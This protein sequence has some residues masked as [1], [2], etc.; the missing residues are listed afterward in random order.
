MKVV[1]LYSGSENLGIESLSAYL[2]AN[3]HETA[4]VFDPAH[5]RGNSGRDNPTLAGLFDPPREKIIR[6]VLKEEPD[7]LALSCVTGNYR[8]A[9]DLTAEI[10]SRLKK[11]VPAVFGGFHPSMAPERVISRPAVDALV[12]GEGEDALL[13]LIRSVKDGEFTDTGVA[14]AW[15]KSEGNIHRNPVRPYIRDLDRLPFPDKKLFYRKVPF[16]RR[17]YMVMTA[18]GCPYNCT[19]CINATYHEIYRA[20]KTHIRRYSPG[21]IIEEL[22]LARENGP[23][24]YINIYDDIFTLDLKWIEEFLP[25]YRREIGLPFF[26]NIHPDHCDENRVRLIKEAGCHTVRLG[27]Q[28]LH[29]PTLKKTLHRGGLREKVAMALDNLRKY[30]IRAKVEYILGLPGDSPE[31]QSDA[32]AFYNEHRPTKVHSFWLIPFPGTKIL[33]TAVQ[34]GL[35]TES[36]AEDFREADPR[37]NFT[38]FHYNPTSGAKYRALNRFPL[39][40][41]LL[42]LLP[43][44]TVAQIIERKLYRHFPYSRTLHQLLFLLNALINNDKEDIGS[45]LYIFVKKF[46]P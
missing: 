23:V 24:D 15:V 31:I 45:F 2:K 44:K 5:F 43:K 6:A 40:F 8:W 21:R 29:D 12:I 11:P 39:L 26:C 4:L 32:A 38:T 3:G 34:R 42:T 28:T 27:V 19:F 46:T 30:G 14:N 10:K 36:E 41:D 25:V 18:R 17:G 16:M 22:K 20:E 35:I 13:E 9:L 37:L 33:A 7:V 1:F